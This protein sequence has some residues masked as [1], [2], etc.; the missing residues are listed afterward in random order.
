MLDR[1]PQLTRVR[2][3]LRLEAGQ[4]QEGVIYRIDFEVGREVGENAHHVATH[5]AIEESSWNLPD[6]AL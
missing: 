3:T 5:V 1:A 4:A 6:K 2:L